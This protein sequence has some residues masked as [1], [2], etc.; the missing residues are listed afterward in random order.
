MR[1]VAL[2]GYLEADNRSHEAQEIR[3]VEGASTSRQ[4]NGAEPA[5]QSDMKAQDSEPSQAKLHEDL[6]P[7][8]VALVATRDG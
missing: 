6:P 7:A 5:N 1:N 8:V 3:D 4:Q 2:Q